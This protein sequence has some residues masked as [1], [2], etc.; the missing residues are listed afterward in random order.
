MI[1]PERYSCIVSACLRGG[2]GGLQVVEETTGTTPAAESQWDGAWGCSGLLLHPR[3][4]LVLCHGQILFP[5]L[6]RPKRDLGRRPF[7]LPGAFLSDLQIQVQFPG[8]SYSTQ[9]ELAMSLAS[10]HA[11]ALDSEPEPPNLDS[12]PRLSSLTPG[13]AKAKSSSRAEMLVVFPCQ[14]F[15]DIFRT[16]FSKSDKWYFYSED[17]DQEVHGEPLDLI[18]FALLWCPGWVDGGSACGEE[19][20]RYVRSECLR[21][22]QPLFSCASPFASFCSEIFMNTHSRGIVSNLAGE[23]NAL[24]L[25]DARCLPGTEGGGV[26]IR[27]KDLYYLAGLVVAPLCWKANEWV[28]LTLVCSITCILDT[29]RRMLNGFEI[30]GSPTL[31]VPG[32]HGLTRLLG[33]AAL[34]ESGRVWGSG[35]IVSPRLII[36]C[37]HV[38]DRALSVRVKIQSDPNSC[39]ELKGR[40]MFATKENSPYDVAVVE[41]EEDLSSIEIPTIA[42]DFKTGED[43]YVIGYGVFGRTC[44]PSVTAGI[45]SAVITMEERPVMLQTTC[46]VHAGASGGP[47]FSNSSGEL[48][49]IVSSNAR[50]NNGGAT[51]PHLNFSLPITVLWPVLSAYNQTRDVAVFEGLNRGSKH[52]RALWRLQGST[53]VPQRS[54]L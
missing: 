34:L 8:T 46:A 20:V 35:V 42:S 51:Y 47:V 10:N 21:K 15:G 52:L 14:A 36:T 31:T 18:W 22:G 37:R 29:L 7:L 19:V 33:T 24:I 45:L 4:R 5:F 16:L 1:S 54:K 43:V 38:I 13:Q 12:R 49:G 30:F 27:S 40:V 6:R 9:P 50:N 53:S 44:G 25:T 41:L 17:H 26:Y 48:L 23:R 3:R 32:S 39:L 11:G 2:G 28:G